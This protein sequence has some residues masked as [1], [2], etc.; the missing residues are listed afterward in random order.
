MSATDEPHPALNPCNSSQRGALEMQ[1]CMGGGVYL[2]TTSDGT[3]NEFS[4]SE[5]QQKGVQI[6]YNPFLTELWPQHPDNMTLLPVMAARNFPRAHLWRRM[7]LTSPPT[8]DI[9]I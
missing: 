4:A 6:I 1:Q 3:K 5:V 8:I 2:L 7:Q 9:G